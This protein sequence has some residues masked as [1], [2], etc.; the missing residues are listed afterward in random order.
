[1]VIAVTQPRTSP[2]GSNPLAPSAHNGWW[3]FP[4]WA[5]EIPITS[6]WASCHDIK[7]SLGALALIHACLELHRNARAILRCASVCDLSRT[8]SVMAALTCSNLTTPDRKASTIDNN[9]GL[10][11]GIRL[12]NGVHRSAW[13]LF[14]AFSCV[15]NHACTDGR[16]N[17]PIVNPMLL[18]I[19]LK[20][21]HIITSG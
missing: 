13:F 4:Q 11:P 20:N 18:R 10:A 19:D 16:L 15:E 7:S 21:T 2:I 14:S 12:S 1:M 9:H 8:H 17:A 3:I 5:V 6:R